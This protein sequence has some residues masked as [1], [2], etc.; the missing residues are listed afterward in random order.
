MQC[1]ATSAVGRFGYEIYGG[2][3]PRSQRWHVGLG[4]IEN[5]Q[6]PEIS[7][8]PSKAVSLFPVVSVFPVVPVPDPQLTL[9]LHPSHQCT[10][11]QNEVSPRPSPPSL[12]FQKLKAMDLPV[13]HHTRAFTTVHR[14][15]LAK[16]ANRVTCQAR[17]TGE[18]VPSWPA[19]DC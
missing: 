14:P 2:G 1:G 18:K 8:Y 16:L 6:R 4:L 19:R 17:A 9:S 13:T 12:D 3:E 11:R 5:V 15:F 10:T 7:N